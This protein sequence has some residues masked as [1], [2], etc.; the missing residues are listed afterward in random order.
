MRDSRLLDVLPDS[1]IIVDKNTADSDKEVVRW[2]ASMM[3]KIDI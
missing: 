3:R 1:V 2:H